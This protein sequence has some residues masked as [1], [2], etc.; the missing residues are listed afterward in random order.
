MSLLLV[1]GAVSIVVFVVDFLTMWIFVVGEKVGDFNA[2]RG[3]LAFGGSVGSSLLL[4]LF[5][6]L[7]LLLF[8]CRR[9]LGLCV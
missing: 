9:V 4:L 8:G 2:G 5:V 1:G 6:L 3:C 7:L